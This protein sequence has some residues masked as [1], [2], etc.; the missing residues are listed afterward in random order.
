MESPETDKFCPLCF[1][2][3]AE[4]FAELEKRED[5]HIVAYVY[6]LS[7]GLSELH[8]SDGLDHR[9]LRRMIRDAYRFTQ[10]DNEG[11]D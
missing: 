11:A 1:A 7:D 3:V 10:P 2:T 4:I 6:H 9:G 5:M 8:F